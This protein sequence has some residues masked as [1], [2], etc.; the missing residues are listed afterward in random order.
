MTHSEN[1]Y[2]FVAWFV[3]D[4]VWKDAQWINPFGKIKWRTKSRIVG[5]QFGDAFE[6]FEKF[7][8]HTRELAASW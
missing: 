1:A 7:A 4:G 2:S 8:C 6:L 3:N 5:Q